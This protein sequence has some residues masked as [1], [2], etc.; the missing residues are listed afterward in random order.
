MGPGFSGKVSFKSFFKGDI[1][2]F[3]DFSHG[4]L[5]WA[6]CDSGEVCLYLVYGRRVACNGVVKDPWYGR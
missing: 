1:G 5:L 6:F 4:L 2:C 3:K